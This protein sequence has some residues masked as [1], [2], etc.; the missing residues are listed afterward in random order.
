MINQVLEKLIE[1]GV[2][3]SE[4]HFH[5]A[6]NNGANVPENNFSEKSNNA[7]RRVEMW[8]TSADLLVMRH[9]NRLFF[10]PMANVKFGFFKEAKCNEHPADSV[11]V[12]RETVVKKRGRP[13]KNKE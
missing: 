5:T 1:T 10:T 11:D 13:F 9:K 8:A 6:V 7:E 2:P 3:V 12:P 4:A